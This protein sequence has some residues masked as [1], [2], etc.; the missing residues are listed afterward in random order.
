VPALGAP[1]PS[2]QESV[3]ALVARLSDDVTRIVRAEIALLQLRASTAL[4][5]VK[6]AST[7]LIAGLLLA[8]GGVG[9]LISALVLAVALVLPGWAAALAVGGG[10]LLLAAVL[11]AVQIRVLTRGVSEA[12]VPAVTETR[13]EE[14][15]HGR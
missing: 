5:A 8:L 14:A 12:F 10:L 3:G 11:L 7:L 4:A 2:E 13:A 15:A 1:T 6:A 9:A